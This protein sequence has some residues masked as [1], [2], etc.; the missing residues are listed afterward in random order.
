M[1]RAADTIL[2]LHEISRRLERICSAIPD[3]PR[4]A[5]W[6]EENGEKYGG[7]G[8]PPDPIAL[9][10]VA[11]AVRR[12]SSPADW[13]TLPSR[14]QR[15]APWALWTGTP[16]P[17][18][19]HGI[20]GAVRD[21][22]IGAKGNTLAR[23][24]IGSY[25]ANFDPEL[26]GVGQYGAAV[27]QVLAAVSHPFHALW[28]ERDA[29]FHLFDAATGPERL[30][31]LLLAAE[32]PEKAL[33]R[34][35][36]TEPALAAS[37][38]LRTATDKLYPMLAECMA[39]TRSKLPL[40]H[41]KP[42]LEVAD[43]NLRFRERRASLATALLKPWLSSAAP[44]EVREAVMMFLLHHLR[45]PRLRAENWQGVDK[46]CEALF[47]RWLAPTTLADFFEF[48]SDRTDSDQWRY[49]RTFW[50]A[51]ADMGVIDDAWVVL[52]KHAIKA[53]R[54]KLGSDIGCGT[55]SGTPTKHQSVLLLQIGNLVFSEISHNGTLHAWRLGDARAPSLGHQTYAWDELYSFGLDFPDSPNPGCLW[56]HGSANY[57]W[58]KRAAELLRGETKI[59][60]DPRKWVP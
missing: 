23:A 4:I 10:D 27:R 19:I 21:A 50:K 43:G 32:Q 20:L 59:V 60:V 1:K 51:L 48:I 9:S 39:E 54:G 2:A 55:I 42:I 12:V 57:L 46:S 40:D 30:A 44:A 24:M 26:P 47:R 5:R 8:K 52:D 11:D 22:A 36:L 49:R 3:S 7:I 53:A 25:F 29:M 41:I 28:R 56:H 16:E 31:R 33:A 6:V 34:S 13:G 38:Y 14:I 37:R 17:I 58:Q 18:R 35:G 45:D 15:L